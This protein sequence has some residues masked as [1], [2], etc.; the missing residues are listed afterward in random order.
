MTRPKIK[1]KNRLRSASPRARY[2]ITLVGSR[3][4]D[5]SDALRVVANVSVNDVAAERDALRNELAEV[6]KA[7]HVANVSVS[8]VAAERDALRNEL[9]E[10]KKALEA[11]KSKAK[12]DAAKVRN[13]MQTKWDFYYWKET[14]VNHEGESL[15]ACMERYGVGGWYSEEKDMVAALVFLS[16]KKT[17][18][19]SWLLGIKQLNDKQ[20][21]ARL[22]EDDPRVCHLSLATSLG[23]Q[24]TSVLAGSVFEKL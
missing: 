8:D 20:M 6:K 21:A 11:V 19:N 4:N 5:M 23:A 10:V 9:A 7:L 12:E 14:K 24:I 3:H 18:G 22:Y 16:A 2:P 13:N 1:R 17:P 15:R